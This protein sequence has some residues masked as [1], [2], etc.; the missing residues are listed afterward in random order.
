VKNPVLVDY[1]ALLLR[2]ALGLMFFAHAWLKIK[3]FTPAGAVKYF[4][5]RLGVPGVLDRRTA[6]S[7]RAR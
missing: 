3:V 7:R 4:R 2:V 5:R 6:G 1:A